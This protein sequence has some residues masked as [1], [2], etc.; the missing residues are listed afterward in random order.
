[1]GG[2]GSQKFQD[3]M[4]ALTDSLNSGIE[5]APTKSSKKDEVKKN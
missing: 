5:V 2:M 1:M 4:K 3:V